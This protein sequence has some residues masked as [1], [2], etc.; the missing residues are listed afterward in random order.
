MA[1]HDHEVGFPHFYKPMYKSLARRF[2]MITGRLG[3]VVCRLVG[4][5]LQEQGGQ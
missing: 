2:C 1:F 4:M 5:A 3:S